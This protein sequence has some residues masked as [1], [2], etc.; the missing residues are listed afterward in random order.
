[1]DGKVI[2]IVWFGFGSRGELDTWT[3][4]VLVLQTV[5][6]KCSQHSL[7]KQTLLVNLSPSKAFHTKEVMSEFIYPN[8][9]PIILLDCQNAFKDLTEKEKLYAHYL[10][11]AS[12]YGGLIDLVQKS[13]ESPLIFSL[14]HRL[15]LTDS[16][17]DLKETALHKCGFSE[18][19]FL[20]FLIYVCGFFCNY[21]NYKSFGD[22]KFIPDLSK[23]KFEKLMFSTKF[24]A[25][26]PEKLKQ[27]L[28]K[29]LDK[30]FS[31]KEEERHLGFPPNATTTYFSKN[32]TKEDLEA[33]NKFFKKQN[34]EAFNSRLF[35][36]TDE[37]G[38]SCFEIRLASVLQTDCKEEKDI[39]GFNTENGHN[40]VV[41]R[42][43]YSKLLKHVND[44]L[45]LA[46]DHADNENETNMIEKYIE[47][48]KTGSQQAHKDGSRYWIKNKGPIVENYIGFIETYKDPDGMR[49]EFEGLVAVV[50]KKMSAK[51]GILVK[52][53]E[54]FISLLPWPSAYE[55]D[56]FLQPDFTS[57]Y[58]LTY[59]SSTVFSGINIPNYDDIRQSEGFKNVALGNVLQ[60]KRTE[61]PNYL[62]KSDVDM[63]MNYENPTFEVC[64]ALHEL[65]G[66]G[67]GKLFHK[68]ANGSFNFD[69]DKVLNFE[70]NEKV[71]SWY[72]EGETY[73]SVFGAMGSAYEECRAEAVAL[74]LCDL[75]DVL[76]I[77]GHEN[78][79]HDI[80]YTS[81]L[82]MALKGL[83][84]LDM[85]D[86]KSEKWLQAHAQARYV[87]LQ[88]MLECGES[89]VKI[90]KVTGK[91]GKPDLLLS[92]DRN[93]IFSVGKAGIGKF[94]A[95]LQLY[96]ATADVTSASKMFDGYS[97]VKSEKK[98]PFLD[99]R[100]IIMERRKPRRLFVQANT[101]IE[102]GKVKIKSY[103][104][105][106]EGMV[107]SWV[108]RFQDTSV[109]DILEELWEKDKQYF[110]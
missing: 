72:E 77:F 23:E 40:F 88:V 54:S 13:P 79:K 4:S 105:T 103:D 51:F 99:Y 91:D 24:A 86:P 62:N 12:W 31:L 76:R 93:K 69:A 6:C 48:F 80:I 92:L 2:V 41:T 55:K 39:L 25:K 47:S 42:G 33:V 97:K 102:D 18:E 87:L 27:L 83:E 11:R 59:A 30:M 58:V 37:T 108:D 7:P 49:G 32:I 17:K 70:T 66:H 57:L 15:F 110:V 28:S 95:R 100:E 5:Y 68:E 101:F 71:S 45:T 82:L 89:F 9:T 61:P 67:S 56:V 52:S 107:Q 43:D 104:S 3:V 94:L 75:P 84:A 78:E 29:C 16:V 35:K 73:V 1:M 19:E 106:P 96:K 34:I 74:Y 44:N 10:S 20:A 85:F 98:Y 22:S 65:L 21:G 14:L 26:F 38:R 109:D 36:T 64:L 53:A 63:M 8:T 46:K 81:W 50:N 60:V 90:E